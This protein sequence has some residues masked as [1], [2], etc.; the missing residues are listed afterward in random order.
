[1]S[2]VPLALACIALPPFLCPLLSS[3]WDCF[4]SGNPGTFGAPCFLECGSFVSRPFTTPSLSIPFAASAPSSHLSSS[5]CVS[6]WRPSWLVPKQRR[7]PS[8]C[9]YA[10]LIQQTNW[11]RDF[12]RLDFLRPWRRAHLSHPPRLARQGHSLPCSR[13]SLDATRPRPRRGGHR[14]QCYFS[15]VPRSGP[16]PQSHRRHRHHAPRSPRL[17]FLAQARRLL[18]LLRQP[19]ISSRRERGEESGVYS[20]YQK[21]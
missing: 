11:R 3:P 9:R 15:C 6:C 4:I 10:R 1:M 17:F 12:Y 13:L 2:Y 7:R 14:G 5:S 20:R 19:A 21:T 8:L 16:I 18:N